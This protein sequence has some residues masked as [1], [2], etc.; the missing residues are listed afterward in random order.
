MAL[1]NTMFGGLLG[2]T[3]ALATTDQEHSVNLS[4]N[5]TENAPKLEP[6]TVMQDATLVFTMPENPTNEAGSRINDDSEAAPP[7]TTEANP[8]VPSTQPCHRLHQVLSD[9]LEHLSLTQLS[10][11]FCVAV[12]DRAKCGSLQGGSSG[13]TSRLRIFACVQANSPVLQLVHTLGTFFDMDAALD[14]RGKVV[15]LVG[16]KTPYGS[17]HL[18]LLPERNAWE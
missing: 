1:T 4:G 16:E 5:T 12:G 9:R 3:C 11:Q 17:P 6:F 13:P 2:S 7:E 18:V 14:L 8:T 10:S 15:A